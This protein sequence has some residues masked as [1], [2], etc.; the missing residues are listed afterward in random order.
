MVTKGRA[1]RSKRF[2]LSARLGSGAK[3][4]A[5]SVTSGGQVQGMSYMRSETSISMPGA[6]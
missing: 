1:R 6:M 3:P 2:A 4:A 5:S